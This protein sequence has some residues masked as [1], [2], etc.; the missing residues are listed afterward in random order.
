M[1]LVIV[2]VEDEDS[3]NLIRELS[4]HGYS[5]TKLASTGGFLLQGNTTVLVGVEDEQ[6]DPVI[7][8]ISQVCVRRR[9]IIPQASTEIPTAI[10]LPI[11][12]EV[13]GAIVFVVSVA[14]FHKM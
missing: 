7:D 9:K 10:N 4:S 2:V 3:Q 5:S 14:E 12:I 1:K 11:E 6:V 13:G 8:I